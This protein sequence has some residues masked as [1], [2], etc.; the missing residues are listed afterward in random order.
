M[1]AHCQHVTQDAD[2]AVPDGSD[3]A[4]RKVW[5][6]SSLRPPARTLTTR[7]QFALKNPD[8]LFA[9]GSVYLYLPRTGGLPQPGQEPPALPTAVP[10]CPRMLALPRR[11]S[12]RKDLGKTNVWDVD[13]LNNCK[14]LFPLGLSLL[15]CC[16]YLSFLFASFF[17]FCHFKNSKRRKRESERRGG[18]GF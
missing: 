13:L 4:G 8:Q 7:R 11:P 12:P 9:S 16:F 15:P 3:T 14:Y 2:F 5:P 10:L 17:V 18:S 6:A 1:E